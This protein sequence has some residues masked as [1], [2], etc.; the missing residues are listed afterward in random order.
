MSERDGYE[1]GVPNWVVTIQPD[2]AAATDFYGGLFGWRFE[3]HDPGGGPGYFFARVRDR[4]AAAVAPLPPGIDPP[5][6]PDWVTHVQVDSADAAAETARSAGGRVV[7]EP[8]DGP[9]GRLAVLADP[10]GAVFCVW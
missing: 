2:P 4:I 9:A 8:F 3:H 7:V 10:A 5:P 1:P 6:A